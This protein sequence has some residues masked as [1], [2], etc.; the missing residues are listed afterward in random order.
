MIKQYAVC[1]ADRVKLIPGIDVQKPKV[2]FDIWKS[3]N[4]RFQQRMVSVV[5]YLLLTETV[6]SHLAFFFPPG[7]RT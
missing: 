3:L 2:Y 4:K 1:L 7:H 5:I 6:I